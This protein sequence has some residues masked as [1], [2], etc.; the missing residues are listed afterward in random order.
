MVPYGF[1]LLGGLVPD[2]AT[3][4]DPVEMGVK[5]TNKAHVSVWKHML[6]KHLRRVRGM[7]C[8]K[9]GK[10]VYNVHFETHEALVT[11]NDAKGWR[12]PQKAWIFTEVNT[13]ILCP[14]CH[15]PQPPTREWAWKYLTE[16]YG[17][18]VSEWYY[19]LPWKTGSPP[20]RF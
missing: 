4:Y 3:M 7:R 15:R 13:L 11:K 6:R 2:C 5:L 20:R 10:S 14:T 19:G 8:D 9:C 16:R 17:D 1:T 12:L 18:K